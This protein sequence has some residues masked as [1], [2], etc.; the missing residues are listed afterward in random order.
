MTAKQELI[1]SIANHKAQ[2]LAGEFS[3]YLMGS[4]TR[5]EFMAVL[6]TQEHHFE[7]LAKELQ[8]VSDNC[9]QS[10]MIALES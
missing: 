7:S 2:V 8:S 3:R 4:I 5:D 6:A 9:V 1:K 10:V